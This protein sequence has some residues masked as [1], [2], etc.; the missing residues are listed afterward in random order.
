MVRSL[1][2]VA[3][4]TSTPVRATAN[5]PT[6]FSGQLATDRIGAQGALFQ[7]DP[8]NVALAY[9]GVSAQMDPTTGKDVIGILSVPVSATQ[10]PFASF[11]P[12]QPVTPASLN[13]ADL[14]VL[15]TT[16]DAV[17]VSYVQG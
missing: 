9:I 4:V 15:G 1:G 8:G 17:L 12:S 16:G 7:A 10:G 6:F 14:W 11:S 13:M 5:V 2:L 3:C